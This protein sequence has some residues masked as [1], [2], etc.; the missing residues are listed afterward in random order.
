MKTSVCDANGRML[1]ETSTSLSVLLQTSCWLPAVKCE[2]ILEPDGNVRISK[3]IKMRQP[4][5]IFIYS[6]T[7][8][9]LLSNKVLYLDVQLALN[10]TFHQFLG[11]KNSVAIETVKEYLLRWCARKEDNEATLFCTS[12][13]HMKQVYSYLS[14]ELNK[15]QLQSLLRDH[16][17]YFVPMRPCGQ[18]EVVP[19]HMLNRQ[20]IWIADRTGLFEKHRGLVE[21]FHSEICKKRT[22]V[23]FYGDT[24]DLLNTFKQDAKVNQQPQV[25]EFMEL[26][27]LLCTTSSPKNVGIFS[28][29]LHIFTVIGQNLANPVEAPDEETANMMQM[30]LIKKIKKKM[31]RE[32]VSNAYLCTK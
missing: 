3:K 19:G 13:S 27:S 23:S 20:E 32:K 26:L 21:E 24:P 1:K 10:S 28:D 14:K 6:E 12:L 11:L 17:V 16:P 5:A 29:V 30:S 9:R 4:A 18:D 15:G 22:L 7:L 8:Q 2:C 25:E 31:K